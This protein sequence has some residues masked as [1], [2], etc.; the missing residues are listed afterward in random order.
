MGMA[1]DI[2]EAKN[3]GLANWFASQVARSPLVNHYA[4]PLAHIASDHLMQQAV[5][6][7]PTLPPVDHELIPP[8]V[9]HLV[10]PTSGAAVMDA[11]QGTG[12]G[13]VRRRVPR[14]A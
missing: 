1:V 5:Q 12:A 14:S 9:R 4:T 8:S 2:L 7:A 3:A 6:K 10:Q 11:G 13:V